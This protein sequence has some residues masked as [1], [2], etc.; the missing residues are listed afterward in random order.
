L[1]EPSYIISELSSK[2]NMRLI[3][4]ESFGGFIE[5][6]RYLFE[7]V[8]QFESN[9]RTKKSLYDWAAFYNDKDPLTA[10]LKKY[11]QLHRYYIFRMG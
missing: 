8:I 4:T 10:S 7:D 6:N 1:V 5:T 2:C 11:S 3:E 9:E